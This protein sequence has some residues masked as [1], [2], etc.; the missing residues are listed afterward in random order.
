MINSVS[1]LPFVISASEFTTTTP[2]PAMTAGAVVGG[3]IAVLI[4]FVIGGLSMMG[5]FKKAGRKTWEAFI[6]VYSTVVLLRIAGM[7]AWWILLALVPFASFVLIIFL[8]INL[9]KVFGQSALIAVLIALF[10]LVM[11]FYLSY[12]SARYFGP[13]AS[14]GPFGLAENPHQ[15]AYT[16][17][18][19]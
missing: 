13:Q 19:R 11:Y 4:G 3:L 5:M 18:G 9:A 6:P 14:K 8:A 1:S 10:G 12:S 2:D 17:A 7:S 15:P 16:P